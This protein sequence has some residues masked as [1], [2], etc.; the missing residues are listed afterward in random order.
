MSRWTMPRACAAA[1]ARAICPPH[2]ATFSTGWVAPQNLRSEVPATSSMA[3]ASLGLANEPFGA[4]S[5]SLLRDHFEGHFAVQLGIAGRIHPAHSS[6][7]D[8]TGDD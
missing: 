3:I 4:G 2:K 1:R 5:C 8:E 7:P 6:L